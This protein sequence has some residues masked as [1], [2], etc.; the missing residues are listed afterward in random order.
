MTHDIFNASNF[1]IAIAFFA[2]ILAIA[3]YEGGMLITPVV[4]IGIA[5]VCGILSVKENGKRK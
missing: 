2:V 5:V 1:F 3:A 4:L